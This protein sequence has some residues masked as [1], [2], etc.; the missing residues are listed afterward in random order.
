MTQKVRSHKLEKIY[1]IG[2]YWYFEFFEEVDLEKIETEIKEIILEFEQNYSRFLD[3]SIVSILNKNRTLTKPTHELIE[4]L[5][6]S[7]QFYKDTKGIFN[8]GVGKILEDSGYDKNYSFIKTSSENFIPDLNELLQIDSE[9][10]KLIGSGNIDLG[11]IGKGF[12]IDKLATFFKEK[13][14]LKYFLINGGGDI[15]LTSNNNEPLKILLQSPIHPEKYL[16]EVQ[17]KNCSICSSSNL[18]RKWKDKKTGKEMGHIVNTSEKAELM[19]T[20]VIAENAV[21]ADVFATVLMMTNRENLGQQV[22]DN[23]KL[24]FLTLDD[25]ENVREE[26]GFIKFLIR[27]K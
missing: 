25:K 15:Y 6:T 22:I 21:S 20:F 24:K 12:L 9:E 11:G 10:I 14:N 13:L 23:Y 17:L 27:Q 18:K 4:L 5:T 16:F 1:G 19:S 26:F 7:Q 2:T 3:S 8:I